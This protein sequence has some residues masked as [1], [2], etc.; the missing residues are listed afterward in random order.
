[1]DCG[2]IEKKFHAIGDNPDPC[3]NCNGTKLAKKIGNIVVS[4]DHSEKITA[5]GNIENFI[6]D[7]KQNLDLMKE[8]SKRREK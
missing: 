8:E 3:T 5:K 2:I 6:K 7:S 1:L 4:N